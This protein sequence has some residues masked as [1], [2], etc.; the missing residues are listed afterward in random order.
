[1]ICEGNCGDHIG[2]V[3]KTRVIDPSDW[4]DWGWFNYCETAIQ[5]DREA[6]LIVTDYRGTLYQDIPEATEE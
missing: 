1:M 4:L 3:T 6:G 5:D 2:K